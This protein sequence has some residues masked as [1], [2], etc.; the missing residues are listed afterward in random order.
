MSA[1]VLAVNQNGLSLSATKADVILGDQL[2]VDILKGQDHRFH[3][4]PGQIQIVDTELGTEGL[5]NQAKS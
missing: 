5:V 2:P 4:F 1:L 3:L